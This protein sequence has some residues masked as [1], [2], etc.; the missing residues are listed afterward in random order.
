MSSTSLSPLPEDGKLEATG[1]KI[2]R[3]ESE[4]EN[5]IVESNGPSAVVVSTVN[6]AEK[7]E[8]P[9]DDS[10]ATKVKAVDEPQEPIEYPSGVEVLFIMLALA[11]SIILISLDQV[12]ATAPS[13]SQSRLLPI[14]YMPVS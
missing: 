9:E 2:H 10:P 11:L 8:F 3:V 14:Y 12:S 6:G 4:K 7:P 13:F 5:Q 1:E